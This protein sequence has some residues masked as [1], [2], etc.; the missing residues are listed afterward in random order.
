MSYRRN[1]PVLDYKILHTTGEIKEKVV[2]SDFD[3]LVSR[4][5]NVHLCKMSTIEKLQ[6]NEYILSSEIDEFISL[7]EVKGLSDIEYVDE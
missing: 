7:N 4:L 1:K 2:D 6:E 3:P 5:E